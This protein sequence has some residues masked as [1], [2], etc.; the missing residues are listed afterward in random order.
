MFLDELARVS[1]IFKSIIPEKNVKI[2]HHL[3]ADGITSAAIFSKM[4]MREGRGFEMRMLKQLTEDDI[5]GLSIS[6]GDLLVLLDF[7][8][9]QL[10]ALKPIMERTQV[11]ILDHHEF[12]MSSIRT[13]STLT[14]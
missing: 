2:L 11:L 9:G 10:N 13:S 3:D 6:E 1:K 8:S 14:R 5:A 7:G 4:M 12:P